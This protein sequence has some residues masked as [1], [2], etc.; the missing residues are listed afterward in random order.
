[1]DAVLSGQELIGVADAI[2]ERA[3]SGQVDKVGGEYIVHPRSVASRV[4]PREPEYIA[5]ALLHDVIEDTSYTASDLLKAGIPETVVVAVTLLTR[6]DDVAP[7]DYYAGIRT[8]EMALAVKLADL[9]D[10][11][12]P[13]RLE[14]L[15]AHTQDRLRSKYRQAYCELGASE[16]AAAL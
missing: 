10:N 12:D 3:H 13:V 2:A 14:R 4:A 15:P 5:T 16:L 11:T 6:R 8:D 9:A 7:I 1:M